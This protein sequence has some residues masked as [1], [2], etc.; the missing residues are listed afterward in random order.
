MG[1]AVGAEASVRSFASFAGLDG[2]SAVD[3]LSRVSLPRLVIDLELNV[4]WSNDAADAALSASNSIRRKGGKLLFADLLG[5]EYWR[6]ALSKV[7]RDFTRM[8]VMDSGGNA[9]VILGACRR[10]VGGVDALCISL[11][12]VKG[13]LDLKECGLA[14]KF[15]L[16]DSEAHIAQMLVDLRSPREISDELG[17]SIN[18]VRTHVRGIYA[19]LAVSSQRQL[20]RLA[21]SY[22]M[23]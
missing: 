9:D 10:I 23:V 2:Q 8:V 21:S 7:G 14:E 18:T 5:R 13:S 11:M 22:C 6:E 4:L 12:A 3:W 1:C 17:I 20:V 16:T 15:E 19:K